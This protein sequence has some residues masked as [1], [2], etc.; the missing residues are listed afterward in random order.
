MSQPSKT[1]NLPAKLKPLKVMA[2]QRLETMELHNL[3]PLGSTTLLPPVPATT[4]TI[5]LSAPTTSHQ[6]SHESHHHL[7]VSLIPVPGPANTDLGGSTNAGYISDGSVVTPVNRLESA[8]SGKLSSLSHVSTDREGY[9]SSRILS[10][11]PSPSAADSV[12]SSNGDLHQLTLNTGKRGLALSDSLGLPNNLEAMMA[13]RFSLP[14]A[15]TIEHLSPTSAKMSSFKSSDPLTSSNSHLLASRSA[16]SYNGDLLTSQASSPGS[17][18]SRGMGRWFQKRPSAVSSISSMSDVS[19]ISNSLDEDNGAANARQKLQDLVKS[20]TQRAKKVGRNEVA[21]ISTVSATLAPPPIGH[22]IR[23]RLDSFAPSSATD[24]T[25][26]VQVKKF[27]CCGMHRVQK[28]LL[29]YTIPDAIDPTGGM[30]LAWLSIV[31]LFYIYNAVSIFLRASFTGETYG[32]ESSWLILDYIGD[33]V[34]LLDICLRTRIIYFANGQVVRERVLLRKHYTKSLQFKFDVVCLLPLDLLYFATGINPIWRLP[35]LLKGHSYNEF[36]EKFENKSKSANSFR[37]VKTIG[38]MLYMIHLNTCCY[39]VISLYEGI[40][41]N[42]WVYNG[43]GNAYVRCLFRATKTLITIGNLPLPLTTFEIFFMN[44]DFMI[45]VFVFATII[46]QMR[47]IVGAA[48][49]TKGAFRRRMDNTMA[50]LQNWK[51]PDDVQRRVR[52]WFMYAW[53]RREL[54]DEQEIMKNVPIKMQTDIAIHV[55]MD[56][57]SKVSLFQDCDKMLLRDLVLKLRPVLFLPGDYICRKGEVGKEMYI[58]KN[59]LVQVLGGQ[60]N[61]TVLATLHPGS[62]FGEISLLSVGVGNRRTADVYSPGYSN[63]FVLDKKVLQEVVVNYPNAQE[64]LKRKAREILK[65]NQANESKSKKRRGKSL[66]AESILL[67]DRNIDSSKFFNAVLEVAR[68]SKIASTILRASYR[69]GLNDI[70][71][72]AV[73]FSNS[74]ISSDEVIFGTRQQRKKRKR[75]V[76]RAKKQQHERTSNDDSESQNEQGHSDSDQ[77]HQEH[78]RPKRT[79]RRTASVLSP[80]PGDLNMPSSSGSRTPRESMG[81]MNL[82]WDNE[83]DKVMMGR[84]SIT[85]DVPLEEEE[86][87]ATMTPTHEPGRPAPR[88]ATSKSSFSGIKE[89]HR[90]ARSISDVEREEKRARKKPSQHHAAEDTQRSSSALPV[91]MEDSGTDKSGHHLADDDNA[92]SG[93]EHSEE[94]IDKG[95]SS[96]ST[97][98]SLSGMEDQGSKASTLQGEGY[99]SSSEASPE[100][101][102]DDVQSKKNKN[103]P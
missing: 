8:L 27:N 93:D 59:G 21:P 64:S 31:A 81:N 35:R 77:V 19:C 68:T 91:H 87:D 95:V 44:I 32:P 29:K 56:T 4:P 61:R 23:K 24:T 7:E 76:K 38:Y 5:C 49:A 25:E 20:V 16:S 11:S 15:G 6:K 88:K 39:Y 30:W 101:R 94:D 83:E 79:L 60:N 52:L 65:K 58:I 82:L 89:R 102:R 97:T 100:S 17:K 96:D 22:N 43:E 86:A 80:N 67:K 84:S 9:Q 47:D 45:G 48:G 70:E 12:F 18:S 2:H 69:S 71:D 14:N 55:H 13:K 85:G 62:Y 73:Q 98:P 1:T 40:G 74:D 3:Q 33:F 92:C 57:L 72:E 90:M 42:R 28:F 63:L 37:I 53:D 26:E 99:D 50:L 75:L 66:I 10:S 34:F 41:I 103:I 46:G 54:L 78:L 36:V 51:I